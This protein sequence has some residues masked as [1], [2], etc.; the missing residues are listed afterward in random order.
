M[1][2]FSSR[3]V[4]RQFELSLP[5]GSLFVNAHWLAELSPYF[6]QVCFDERFAEANAGRVRIEGVD[7]ADVLAM[8]EYL[9]PD[10]TYMFRKRI[11]DTN[12][13]SLIHCCHRFQIPSLQLDLERF[14][15]NDLLL[16]DCHLKAETLV[17][18]IIEARNAHF[19]LSHLT[20]LHKKLAAH[21]PETVQQAVKDIPDEVAADVLSETGK[22]MQVIITPALGSSYHWN[23][24]SM[25]MFF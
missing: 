23:D 11:A 14:M 21:G 3:S 15:E 7:Y 6:R 5:G 18:A 13:P 17:G 20:C 12:L 2:E 1:S 10:K 24:F 22:H 4:L 19:R 25:R 8:L 16:E 9:C